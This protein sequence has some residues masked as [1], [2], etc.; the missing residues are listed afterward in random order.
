MNRTTC[1]NQNFRLKNEVSR[2]EGILCRKRHHHKET[3]L[4]GLDFC[5]QR[6]LLKVDL[7]IMTK[8][9]LLLIDVQVRFS[10]FLLVGI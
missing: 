1:T 8:A 7:S 5:K 3:V 2:N 9:A 6:V 4:E 10:L